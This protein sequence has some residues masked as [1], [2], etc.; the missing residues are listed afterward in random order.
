M[1]NETLHGSTNE[2]VLKAGHNSIPEY[3]ALSWMPVNATTT[4]I[5][6]LIEN[7]Y[8]HQTKGE[9]PVLHPTSDTVLFSEKVT[10]SQLEK[11]K[12]VLEG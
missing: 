11:L 10:K 12:R 6:W 5:N 8:L 1:L 2:K 4:A 9:Y 3:G 7:H